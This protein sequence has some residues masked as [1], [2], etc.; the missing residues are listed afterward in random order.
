MERQLQVFCCYAREDQP[1]LR[2]LKMHLSPYQRAGLIRVQ[3]DIDI[4]PGE[5]WEQKISQFLNT[6]HMILLLVSPGFIDSDYCYSKEMRRAMERHRAG[7]ARVIPIILRP[8]DWKSSPLRILQA[9]PSDALPITNWPHEDQAFFDVA[10]GIRSVIEKRII[11]LQSRWIALFG[12]E[13]QGG[14]TSVLWSNPAAF[15]LTEALLVWESAG[16]F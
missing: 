16:G 12:Y 1:Y 15:S 5:E 14:R 9:L 7:E 10:Q 8:V 2:K 3:T 11:Q 4:S 13:T 6:A